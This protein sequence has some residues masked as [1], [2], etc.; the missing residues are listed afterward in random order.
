M[1]KTM[2][3]G[4]RF[5]D[6]GGSLEDVVTEVSGREF[7]VRCLRKYAYREDLGESCLQAVAELAGEP[8]AGRVSCARLMGRAM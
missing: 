7:D 1:R 6:L 8:F 3:I 5:S 2:T 4:D